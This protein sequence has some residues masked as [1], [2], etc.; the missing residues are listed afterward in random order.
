MSKLL[1]L[2]TMIINPKHISLIN[3][4]KDSFIIHIN[5]FNF[6]VEGRFADGYA[7]VVSNNVIEIHKNNHKDY[8]T[9]ADYILRNSSI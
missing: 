7:N 9:I 3:L 2:S 8:F 1:K 5:Y 6:E 4:K